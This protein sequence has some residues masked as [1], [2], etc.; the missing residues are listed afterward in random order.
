MTTSTIAV[1][2]NTSETACTEPV[3]IAVIVGSVR[4]DLCCPVPV[5]WIADQA[6]KREDMEVDQSG[7]ADYDCPAVLGGNDEN[8]PLP[9]QVTKRSERA[10]KADGFGVCAWSVAGWTGAC[11]VA[12]TPAFIGLSA[13]FLTCGR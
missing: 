12:A 1:D 9:E 2:Q 5:N 8:A 6:R 10:D 13:Q 7:L 11:A 4:T 3:R